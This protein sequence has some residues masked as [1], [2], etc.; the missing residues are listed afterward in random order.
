MIICLDEY[1]IEVLQKLLSLSAEKDGKKRIHF[2]KNELA[3]TF[4]MD[5]YTIDD[6]LY[7]LKVCR[8][9]DIPFQNKYQIDVYVYK[10]MIEE[11]ILKNRHYVKKHKDWMVHPVSTDA[12]A[13]DISQ[14]AENHEVDN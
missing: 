8:L 2:K 9:I 1:Q 6:I 13:Y 7:S 14:G 4:D 3:K 12:M 11:Q 10:E 5:Y